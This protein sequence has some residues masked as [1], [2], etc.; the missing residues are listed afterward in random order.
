MRVAA[1]P[2]PPGAA[3]VDRRALLHGAVLGIMLGC[4]PRAA[5]GAVEGIPFYAPAAGDISSGAASGLPRAGFETLL[6]AVEAMRDDI[7]RSREL[8]GRMDWTELGAIDIAGRS[9]VLG[10]FAAILGDDAYATDRNLRSCGAPCGLPLVR[11]ASDYS[12]SPPTPQVHRRR[13][14]TPV[15]QCGEAAGQTGGRHRR[16]R[17]CS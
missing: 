13:A 7:G 16:G 2:Q 6:P 10:S 8:L 12:L 5:R 14:E 15:H 1:L 4:T 9:N 11:G 3:S 17:P